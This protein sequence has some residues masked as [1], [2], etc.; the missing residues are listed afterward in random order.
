MLILVMNGEIGRYEGIRF[1]EQT[2][3]ASESWT[4][5][6]SDAIYFFGD[7]AVAEGIVVP[8]EIRAKDRKSVV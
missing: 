6:L 1:V 5:S 8:E 4:N 3:I 7:D 2:N